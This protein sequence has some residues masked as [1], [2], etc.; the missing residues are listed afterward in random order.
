MFAS[1]HALSPIYTLESY[2]AV[3]GPVNILN[4]SKQPEFSVYGVV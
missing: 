4:P 1:A 2:H 3:N